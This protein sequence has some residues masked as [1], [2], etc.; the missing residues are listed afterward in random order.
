MGVK[1]S[2]CVAVTDDV[3]EVVAVSV[4]LGELVR[5][6]VNVLLVVLE[7]EAVCVGVKLPVSVSVPLGEP[8]RDGVNVLLVV[9][10]AEAV[11]VGVKL[12]VDVSVGDDV[13]DMD[14]ADCDTVA[15]GEELSARAIKFPPSML[16]PVGEIIIRLC[17]M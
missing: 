14:A 12:A 15:D 11:C 13:G 3:G 7:T 5:D 2:V 6:G 1:L 10:E 8:V 9:L 17:T 4:L 16:L